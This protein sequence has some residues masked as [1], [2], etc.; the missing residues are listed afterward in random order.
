MYDAN[1]NPRQSER[2]ECEIRASL[3]HRLRNQAFWGGWEFIF[4]S[5]DSLSVP[6]MLFSS[7]IKT[8]VCVTTPKTF[9][10]WSKYH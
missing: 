4:L 8:L 6:K 5:A 7:K 1:L 3:I 9:Y 2:A 10:L